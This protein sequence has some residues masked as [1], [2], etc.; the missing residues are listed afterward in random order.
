MPSVM[1]LRIMSEEISTHR[2]AYPA[3]LV[4][5]GIGAFGQAALLWHELV[6]T[7]PYKMMSYPSGAF[8]AG[9]GNTGLLA[10]PILAILALNLSRPRR[11]W[12]APA[13]PVVLCPVIFW[14]VYKAAFLLREVRG[15]VEVGRNFDGTTP[16]MVEQQFTHYALSLGLA[17]LCIGLTCGFVLWLVFR[18]K[19]RA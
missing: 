5:G 12:I 11:L 4:I 2:W 19:R 18:L 17:G 16:A 1:L 6:N 10:A 3:V 8:Y 9:I 15:S 14:G 13:L 7:Y